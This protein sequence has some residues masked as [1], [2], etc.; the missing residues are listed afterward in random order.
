[1]LK[2]QLDKEILNCGSTTPVPQEPGLLEHQGQCLHTGPTQP[3]AGRGHSSQCTYYILALRQGGIAHVVRTK[4]N[5]SVG[6][7]Q[8]FQ[9]DPTSP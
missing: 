7:S 3:E 9:W 8:S 6:E 1:M 4:Q 2:Q 5:L